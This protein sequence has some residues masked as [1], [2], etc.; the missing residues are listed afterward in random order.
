MIKTSLIKIGLIIVLILIG[1]CSQRT[2]STSESH[3]PATVQNAVEEVDL[4]TITLSTEA[5][6]RLG[7]QTAIVEYRVVE[8]SRT[9]GGEVIPGSG[10]SATVT[11]PVSGTLLSP[12]TGLIPTAGKR[13]TAGQTLCRLLSA[14]PD[15]DVLSLQ[16]EAAVKKAEYEL[17]RTRAVRAQQLL[18]DKA[19]SVREL[20][21]AQA[22][23]T[24]AEVAYRIAQA[25]LEL[26]EEGESDVDISGLST[27]AIKS[28]VDGVIQR[29][30][31]ASGQTVTGATALF[32]IAGLNPLWVKV[33]VYVGDLE[34]I[35]LI[36][37]ARVH[38]L[39]D[40]AARATRIAPP[41]AAPFS[42]DPE[43]V[44]AEL[45]YELSNNDLSYI[46]GQKVSVTLIQRTSERSL[47]IP[48]SSIL[49]D[50]YGS[51][52]V[53]ENTGPQ[54][55]V[56]QRVNLQYVLDDLAIL[57]RGPSAG[58]RVVSAG[59]AELFGTEFGVGH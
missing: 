57:S 26:I 43:A 8:K 46:P 23:L 50:M 44:T 16:E 51:A 53:Y 54:V 2:E 18:D 17:A 14:L 27:L 10:S 45:Y 1:G 33:P 52:W 32:E 47:I 21:E 4:T 15:R 31:V 35:D 20:E 49:Y 5:E 40:F 48:Y 34:T 13:V 3:S 29:V 39:T 38:T 41:V 22:E 55:Y 12:E 7:I 6:T 36:K 28:P 37:P 30:H 19:G 58:A 9:F 24:S 56:R 42:A 59:A 11:A 25:K